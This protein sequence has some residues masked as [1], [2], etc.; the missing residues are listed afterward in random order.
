MARPLI[1]T[2]PVTQSQT[3]IV[4]KGPSAL[5][6]YLGA[7][8]YAHHPAVPVAL[9]IGVGLLAHHK[10]VDPQKS[11]MMGLGAAV[12]WAVI[13]RPDLSQVGINVK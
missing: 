7:N 10:G 2:M 8:G 3:A 13:F 6:K 12:V 11:A 4:Q 9:G 5:D 1:A